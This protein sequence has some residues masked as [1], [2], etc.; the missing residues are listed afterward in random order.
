[1]LV[2]YSSSQSLRRRR[3]NRQPFGSPFFARSGFSLI[4]LL[5][6]IGILTIVA[7]LILPAVR[8]PL[9]RSRLR[10]SAVDVQKAWGSA[11]TLAIREGMAMEFRCETGG[12]HWKIERVGTTVR[13]RSDDGAGATGSGL[14]ADDDLSGGLLEDGLPSDRLMR[15]GWLPEGV[16][17]DD[18]SLQYSRPAERAVSEFGV[19]SEQTGADFGS[20]WSEPLKFLPE[21]RSEDA[22]LRIRGADGFVVNVRIRGLT[23]AVSF[24]RPFRRQAADRDPGGPL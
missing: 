22:R 4:E 10:S 24:S 8:G 11:R 18:L 20:R 2:P 14:R 1:M 3:A 5:I 21:G 23:S 6:V 13:V 12:R 9:E 19:E 15:E 7:A 17:F 16:A